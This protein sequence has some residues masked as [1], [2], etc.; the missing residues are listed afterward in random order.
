M[1]KWQFPFITGTLELDTG[2]IYC[3]SSFQNKIYFNQN[4]LNLLRDLFADSFL[5]ARKRKKLSEK[6]IA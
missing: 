6:I 4:L 3:W 5:L 1:Y 2:N